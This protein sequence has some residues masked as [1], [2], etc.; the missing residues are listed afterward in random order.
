M[1]YR[2]VWGG[3]PEDIFISTS[4]E[5]SVDDLDAMVRSAVGDPRFRP[6]LNVLLDH[7]QT[8]WWALSNDEIRRRADLIVGDAELLGRQR[9]AFVVGSDVDYG[10]GRMLQGLVH[11]HVAFES[12]VFDSVTAARAWLGEEQ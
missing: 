2:I 7:T 11:D 3:S 12:R 1:E 9:I 10:I 8:A 6:G 4:G 5:A